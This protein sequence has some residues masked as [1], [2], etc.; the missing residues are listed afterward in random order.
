[1]NKSLLARTLAGDEYFDD[2]LS[3]GADPK[4]II[5][6]MGGKWIAEIEELKGMGQ[7]DV[8]SIKAM[9]S[10]QVDRATLKWKEFGADVPRQFVILGTTNEAQIFRDQTGN[11]RFWPVTVGEI[12]IKGVAADRDQLWAEAAHYEAQGESLELPRELWAAAGD[13]QL[14]REIVHPI[15]E[16]LEAQ[17][18]DR[19]GTILLGRV[20]LYDKNAFG[21]H[22]RGPISHRRRLLAQAARYAHLA[23]HARRREN[24]PRFATKRMLETTLYEESSEALVCWWTDRR[25]AAL[26]PFEFQFAICAAVCQAPC[27]AEP[28]LWNLESS[29]FARVGAELM[30]Y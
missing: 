8:E 27:Q 29:V 18:S 28:A 30:Q 6:H 2:S 19:T 1:M 3:I 26:D 25:T 22:E 9:L 17:L 20:V 11:R 16:K 13:V 23:D 12:D 5:E 24:H 7:R 15:V 4:A 21:I 14:E 10:K